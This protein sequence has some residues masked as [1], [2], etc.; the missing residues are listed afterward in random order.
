VQRTFQVGAT[1]RQQLQQQGGDPA[2]LLQYLVVQLQLLVVKVQQGEL[3]LQRDHL[4][5]QG[6]TALPLPLVPGVSWAIS[7]AMLSD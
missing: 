5:L 7:F 1:L 3:L 4:L 6:C 2:D